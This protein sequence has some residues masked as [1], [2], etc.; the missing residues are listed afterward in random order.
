[1]QRSQCL[2]FPVVIASALLFAAL[3]LLGPVA[4]RSEAASCGGTDRPAYSMSGDAASKVTLCLINKE[5][6]SRGMKPLRFD[7]KQEKAA[8]KHNKVMLRQN[9]FSHL[10]PGEK[11]LVGRIAA[12]GY[13]PCTCTWGI[14]ENLAWGEGPESTPAKV[15]TAWM[16][17]PDHRVNILN[18]KYDEVGIAIDDGSPEGSG[19]AAATYTVDFGF[20]D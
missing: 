19:S 8:S 20:K 15:V 18:P 9:C 2:P 3:L 5:R 17:S 10:C 11:D 1:M 16:N 12:V 4:E 13:L 14:A 6:S 7:K